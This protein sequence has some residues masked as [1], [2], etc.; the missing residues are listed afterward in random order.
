MGWLGSLWPKLRRSSGSPGPKLPSEERQLSRLASHLSQVYPWYVHGIYTWFIPDISSL[1][2]K[3]AFLVQLICSTVITCCV[4]VFPVL[5]T[6]MASFFSS[7]VFEIYQNGICMAYIIYYLV[8]QVVG[9]FKLL[10]VVQFAGKRC[11]LNFFLALALECPH[12]WLR[13]TAL[14]WV[15]I[16]T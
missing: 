11:V 3:H 1:S 10:D 9:I 4:H 15:N 16:Q 8:F 6:S 12:L 5:Q 7:K 13:F 14:K 2:V